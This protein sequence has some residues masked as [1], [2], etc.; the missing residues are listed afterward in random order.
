ME[1]KYWYVKVIIMIIP[2][3]LN[4]QLF[5]E[6]ALKLCFVLPVSYWYIKSGAN[7]LSGFST[8]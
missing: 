3:K 5:K 1:C 7:A 6:E 8:P 2:Y 4:G